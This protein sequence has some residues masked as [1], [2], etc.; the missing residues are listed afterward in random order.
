MP[1]YNCKKFLTEAI[2]SLINQTLKNFEL[3]I[4]DDC[5][6]DGT[7]Q[8]LD[9]LKDERIRIVR[10]TENTGLVISLNQGLKMAQGKYIARMDGDDVSDPKRFE[11]QVNFLDNNPDIAGCGT[12]YQLLGSDKIV[13]NPVTAEDV[14][15]ALLDYCALG[16]PTVMLRKAFLEEKKMSYDASCYP[17]E[18]YELWTRVVADGKLSNIPEVLLSYRI[19]P[20]QVSAMSQ[21]AQVA[22][23]NGCK[24]KMINYLTALPTNE[25]LRNAELL[26]AMGEVR[27]SRHLCQLISWLDQLTVVNRSLQFYAHTGFEIYIEK[28]KAGFIRRYYLHCTAYNW[29]VL[30]RFNLDFRRYFTMNELLRFMLK[31]FLSWK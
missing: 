18:D 27:D 9:N 3:I 23:S 14:K 8:I 28:K 31:C 5:S 7:S 20:N 13:K 26:V 2:E 24:M 22:L 11:K 10:K 6:T 19:H 12:W 30:K 15:I 17:A 21:S 4:I 25:D 16:H 29:E 1:V